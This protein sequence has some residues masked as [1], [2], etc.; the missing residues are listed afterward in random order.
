MSQTAALSPSNS[1]ATRPVALLILSAMAAIAFITAGAYTVYSNMQQTTLERTWADHS[2]AVLNSLQTQTQRL[3]RIDYN[4]QL[5]TAT[6]DRENL[7]ASATSAAAIGVSLVQLQELVRDNESQTRHVLELDKS[8]QALTTAIGRVGEKSQ[9]TLEREILQARDGVSILQQEERGLLRQR[10]DRSNESSSR[11]F[12]LSLV[13]LG[14]SLLIILILF[15][16]LFRDA[17]RR[18]I[19]AASLYASNQVLATTVNKLT[20]RAHE[21]ELL[22][23]ARDELQLCI[24]AAQAHDCT[25]RHMQVLL[26]GTNGSTL[27]INNSRRMVEVVASWGQPT[28]LLDGFDLDACCGLR[29]GKPRWRIPGKAELNCTHFMGSTP[30]RY[31]C[32]PLAAYGETLGFIFVAFPNLDSLTFAESRSPLI[33]ELAELASLSIAGLN[34]RGKLERQSIRDGLTGLFNRHFM[35]IALERELHR[36]S[37]QETNLAVLM[38]DV[39]HF[40]VF[41]DT[42][43]HEAGDVVLREVAECFRNSLRAEDI[44][45]RYGGE[46]FVAIMPDVSEGTALERAEFIRQSVSSI[47]MHFRGELLR[48]V[49][50][51][52]GIALFPTA[53]REGSALIRMADTALYRAKHNGRNQICFASDNRGEGSHPGDPTNTFA[54][55]TTNN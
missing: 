18:R 35:E 47:R 33:L 34:L 2:Q 39:D 13:F 27:I 37:R 36:A 42:F 25:V 20:D 51:S 4:L 5:F 45:C 23:G 16:F 43:G 32:V 52:I 11:S 1:K 44:V 55:L 12:V 31:L 9:P 6:G 29:G 21:S 54:E 40:K 41:N 30:D 19:D 15:V 38:M 46:E 10:T 28:T 24:T 3:D 17:K 53:G 7:R 48:S 26:P 14:V 49:T 50:I 8:L 22:T